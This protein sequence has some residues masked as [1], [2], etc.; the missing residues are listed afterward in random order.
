MLGIVAAI[1]SATGFSWLLTS[2]SF[3][4]DP[5]TIEVSSLVYTQAV[6]IQE[7]IGIPLGSTP[8]VFRI[9]TRSMRRALEALPAVARA[10]VQVTLPDRLL[11]SVSE[12]TPTFVL[13]TLRGSF[14]LDVDGFVLDELLAADAPVLG[15]PVVD[16]LREQFAPDLDVGG[17]LDTVS[18]DATLR[19]AVIT[20]SLIGTAY[21]TLAL[22]VDDAD[23]YV[24]TAEPDG[25]RAVFGHYTPNLRPVDL[26]DRQVQCL[27]SRV[28]AGEQGIVVIYLSTLDERCGTFL[29]EGTP[30]EPA[31]PSPPA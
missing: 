6:A 13:N 21:E 24:L 29:P 22:T 26:I 9:D 31:P 20:P 19:L 25:W 30:V 3:D 14:V 17:R 15:L 2:H 28:E 4:L 16:D 5:D 11:V 10:D 1:V 23:G 8:N 18:L 7:A 27:R 12:R